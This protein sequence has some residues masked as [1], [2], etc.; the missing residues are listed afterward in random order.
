MMHAETARHLANNVRK[1]TRRDFNQALDEYLS[2]TI[3]INA[4]RGLT[5]ATIQPASIAYNLFQMLQER[6]G[7]TVFADDIKNMGLESIIVQ[8]DNLCILNGYEFSKIDE[9]FFNISWAKVDETKE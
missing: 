8:I 9:V 2:D 4:E 7:T 5:D 6:V 3:K 1:I